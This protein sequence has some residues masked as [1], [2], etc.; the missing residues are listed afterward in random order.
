MSHRKCVR[1]RV[2][3]VL[4]LAA[5][6]TPRCAY[7]GT[8]PSRLHLLTIDHIVPKSRGGRTRKENAVLCCPHCN[9]SKRNRTPQEWAAD[10]LAAT[11]DLDQTVRELAARRAAD[12]TEYA[13]KVS[14][15]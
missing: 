1:S 6:N 7:C 11:D 4:L 14:V 2:R 5:G 12:A 13:K 9:Q 3:R 10:I 8:I 15:G